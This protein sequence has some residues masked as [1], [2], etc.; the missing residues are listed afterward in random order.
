M[1]LEVGG[2]VP[3]SMFELFGGFGLSEGH[4]QGNAS[5]NRLPGFV[6]GKALAL[7]GTPQVNDFFFGNAIENILIT[8]SV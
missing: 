4:V 6:L 3:A 2:N 5:D 8:L 7:D 1:D